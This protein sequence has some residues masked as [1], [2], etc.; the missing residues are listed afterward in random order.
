MVVG[1]DPTHFREANRQLNATIT[2]DATFKAM[3]AQ[4]YGGVVDHVAEGPRGGYSS[5]APKGFS[6]HHHPCRKGVLQLVP[7]AQHQAPGPVQSVLH[8]GGQGGK[9]V[10]GGGRTR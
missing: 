7:M 8:P 6:W 1:T 4:H 3:M 9:Q 10:W 2:E 5:S